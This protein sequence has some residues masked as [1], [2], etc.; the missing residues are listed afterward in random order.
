MSN[1]VY[2]CNHVVEAMLSSKD[3]NFSN[4][5]RKI[6]TISQIWATISLQITESNNIVA[7]SLKSFECLSPQDQKYI[8]Y[9]YKYITNKD[10]MFAADQIVPRVFIGP[11]EHFRSKRLL[12]GSECIPTILSDF[13]DHLP[14]PP[15]ASTSLNSKQ[16]SFWNQEETHISSSLNNREPSRRN[17]KRPP[18]SWILYR[19]SKHA[20]TVSKNPNLPNCKISTLIAR[21]WARESNEVRERY[22][23]LAER[24]KY[25]HTV[26]NPGY[27][28][29]PRK[30]SEVKRRQKK[31]LVQDT[32]SIL[33]LELPIGHHCSDNYIFDE[34]IKKA[35]E[36]LSSRISKPPFLPESR[37]E[38]LGIY[39]SR[40]L[41]FFHLASAIPV[42][43]S[44]IDFQQYFEEVS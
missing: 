27:R 40:G 2:R 7:L 12:Y 14:E 38:N 13:N 21:M 17:Q 15:S 20:E 35:E 22:K 33:S 29:R 25:Q 19:K 8:L 5:P 6:A 30:S 1:L 44:E 16:P 28:Y 39:S 18:N 24:A 10:G 23:A 11:I 41:N 37:P 9:N 42:N 31:K 4:Y 3:I 36:V 34:K 32:D 43:S 26:D